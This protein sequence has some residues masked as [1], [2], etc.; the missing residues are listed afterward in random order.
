[1]Q[2][3]AHS[4][5]NLSLTARESGTTAPPF[6]EIIP[7]TSE[8]LGLNC[9]LCG[10]PGLVASAVDYLLAQGVPGRQIHFERFDFR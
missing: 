6:L 10:P 5:A 1:L 4:Y 3:L 8:L 2:T 9:Y 7:A